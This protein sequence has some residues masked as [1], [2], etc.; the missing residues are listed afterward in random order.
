MLNLES[1][2]NNSN[3][4]VDQKK[5]ARDI[6]ES[7]LPVSALIGK[8]KKSKS[9]EQQGGGCKIRTKVVHK[10]NDDTLRRLGNN[11]INED[12][13]DNHTLISSKIINKLAGGAGATKTQSGGKFG[14]GNLFGNEVPAGGTEILFKSLMGSPIQNNFDRVLPYNN[15]SIMPDG[16]YHQPDYSPSR[17][18]G[19]KRR[20][21]KN[22][23]RH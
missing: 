9:L 15:E 20:S 23:N 5:I 4:K 19:S 11:N 16:N 21:K 8:I 22:R 12:I 2:M 6:E 3:Y 18:G 1:K 13:F 14:F 7:Y 17:F 10:I